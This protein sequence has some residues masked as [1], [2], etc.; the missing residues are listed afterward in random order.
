[1]RASAAELQ[2]W[3]AELGHA[4]A[5]PIGL[6]ETAI[7][8]GIARRDWRDWT[9]TG[10]AEWEPG[11]RDRDG[12]GQAARIAGLYR[13]TGSVQSELGSRNR[14]GATGHAAQIAQSRPGGPGIA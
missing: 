14:E 10:A 3:D 8:T 11:F 12:E 5:R 9:A 1:M 6:A 7:R 13:G 4:A 2:N